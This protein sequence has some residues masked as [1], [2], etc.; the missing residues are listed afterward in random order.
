MVLF[1]CTVFK[2]VELFLELAELLGLFVLLTAAYLYCSFTS[3]WVGNLKVGSP[4]L[5]AHLS[6][7][8]LPLQAKMRK[9]SLGITP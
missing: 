7:L 3:D 5:R 4:A 9:V 1:F 2:A 8:P 6:H